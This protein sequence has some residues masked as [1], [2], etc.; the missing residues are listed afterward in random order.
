MKLEK[1]KKVEIKKI[2]RK[3]VE[4]LDVKFNNKKIKIVMNENF[5]KDF[6]K[7]N[8]D[9]V[10]ELD[11]YVEFEQKRG[12]WNITLHPVDLEK[13]SKEAKEKAILNEIAKMRKGIDTMLYYVE[14][15]YNEDRTYQNGIDVINDNLKEIEKLS[16]E[17]ETSYIEKIK[18]E[19]KSLEVIETK[20]NDNERQIVDF[21]EPFVKGQEFKYFDKI[22]NK[23]VLV[24]VK[25]TWKHRE[26]DA[27]SL[28]GTEENQWCYYAIVEIIEETEEK[29]VAEVEL[30]KKEIEKIK[31]Y[32]K[33]FE[34]REVKIFIEFIKKNRD[35]VNRYRS[36]KDNHIKISHILRDFKLYNYEAVNLLLN[37]ERINKNM[38]YDDIFEK[39]KKEYDEVF[40]LSDKKN[41]IVNLKSKKEL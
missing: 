24:K 5:T 19:L 21:D 1:E 16:K 7:E 37:K 27:L 32:Y 38:K 12:Y 3:Y 22:N 2:G 40:E 10:V 4:A 6:A 8:L 28:G 30:S 9:K 31:K 17:D 18:A 39:I 20:E 25:K 35:I 34:K 41:Y 33:N 26:P 11:V 36:E 23:E 13:I 15:A 14:K 29:E